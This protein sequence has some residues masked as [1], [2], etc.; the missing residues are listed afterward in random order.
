MNAL[1]LPSQPKCKPKG[2][3]VKGSKDYEYIMACKEFGIKPALP[4]GESHAVEYQD[5]GTACNF[6]YAEVDVQQE[7]PPDVDPEMLRAALALLVY[8]ARPKVV[9]ARA[10]VVYGLLN[11]GN[12]TYRLVQLFGTTRGLYNSAL[13][14]MTSL[15]PKDDAQDE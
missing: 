3:V 13:M 9:A 5:T 11:R 12:K 8:P 10:A 1:K 14:E 15:L 4:P 7:Q 2:T 6:N